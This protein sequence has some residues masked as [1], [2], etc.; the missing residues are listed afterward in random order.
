MKI[1]YL[2]RTMSYSIHSIDDIS[3]ISLIQKGDKRAFSEMFERYNEIMYCL[4]YKY[5]LDRE[6]AEDVVQSVFLYILDHPGKLSDVRNLKNYLYTA[7]KNRTLNII[8]KKNTEI[9]H[10]YQIYQITNIAEND[11]TVEKKEELRLFQEAVNQLT[12]VKKEIFFLKLYRHLSNQE[13]ADTIG[14]SVNTVKVH[15]SQMIK[16]L[17]KTVIK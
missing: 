17:K 13:I 10:N 1:Y 15:W 2:C 5:L 4:A 7:V 8:R 16:I 3:L 14:I 6:M 11:L 12:K 9:K